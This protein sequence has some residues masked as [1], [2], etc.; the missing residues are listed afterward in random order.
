MDINITEGVKFKHFLSKNASYVISEIRK[1]KLLEVDSEFIVV[2]HDNDGEFMGIKPL[3][4]VEK[5]FEKKE[6]IKL[7]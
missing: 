1:E 2:I 3:N 7:V 5:L 6:W 4:S